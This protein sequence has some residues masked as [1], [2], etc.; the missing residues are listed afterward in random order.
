MHALH[1]RIVYWMRSVSLVAGDVMPLPLPM[2]EIS[3][4]PGAALPA[5]TRFTEVETA[6]GD[7]VDDPK[8]RFTPA[9][10]PDAESATA[11][12]KLPVRVTVR[13]TPPVAPGASVTLDGVRLSEMVPPGSGATGPP[14]PPSLVQEENVA[15]TNSAPS[16]RAIEADR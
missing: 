10:T 15:A 5:I 6:L 14:E 12:A 4:V 16:A 2:I 3:V 11:P 1:A 9:G 13:P 7:T 8:V